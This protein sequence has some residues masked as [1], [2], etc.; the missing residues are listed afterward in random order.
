MRSFNE[1][2]GLELKIGVT[3][4]REGLY[5]KIKFPGEE[6]PEDFSDFI[7]PINNEF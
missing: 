7:Y 5:F 6:K 2:V 4:D 1:E 3:M